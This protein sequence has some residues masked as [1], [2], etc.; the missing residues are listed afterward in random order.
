MT[1]SMIKIMMRVAA[2]FTPWAIAAVV[3]WATYSVGHQMGYEGGQLH[4]D[5]TWEWI[6]A[7]EKAYPKATPAPTPI[8]APFGSAKIYYGPGYS[9]ELGTVTPYGDHWEIR[10]TDNI[11]VNAYL[12]RNGNRYDILDYSARVCVGHII[13]D[14]NQWVIYLTVGYTV[15]ADGRVGHIDK[16]GDWQ[17]EVDGGIFVWTTTIYDWLKRELTPVF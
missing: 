3:A 2:F 7:V 1:K 16:N 11:L 9:G 15:H 4:E 5:R 13:Y 8:P 10:A 12:V 6:E 17:L 14:G